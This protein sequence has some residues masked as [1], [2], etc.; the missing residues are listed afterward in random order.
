MYAMVKIAL[1]MDKEDAEEYFRAK[2]QERL[3]MEA[4][5]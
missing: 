5:Q 3:A 1:G 2:H 4:S